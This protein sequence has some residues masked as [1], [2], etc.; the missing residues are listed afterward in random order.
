M[1]TKPLTANQIIKVASFELRRAQDNQSFAM[2][3]GT[4]AGQ[5]TEIQFP[6][7]ALGSTTT[8]LIALYDT[9]EELEGRKPRKPSVTTD[10]MKH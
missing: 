1:S 9:I 2:V 4:R 7:R 3:V 5:K 8:S 6:S 10:K